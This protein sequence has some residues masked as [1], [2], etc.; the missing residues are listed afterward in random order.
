MALKALRSKWEAAWHLPV[1]F[2]VEL[3]SGLSSASLLRITVVAFPGAEN[4]FQRVVVRRYG[5]ESFKDVR[6]P[7]SVSVCQG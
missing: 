7:T 2:E 3:G 5:E 6:A 4:D 1:A